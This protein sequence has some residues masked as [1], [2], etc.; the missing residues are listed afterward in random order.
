MRHPLLGNRDK[1]MTAV[2]IGTPLPDGHFIRSTP[3]AAAAA[4]GSPPEK[5][6]ALDHRVRIYVLLSPS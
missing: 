5:A 1:L 4:G 2:S 3:A 6:S